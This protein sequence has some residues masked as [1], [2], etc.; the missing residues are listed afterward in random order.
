MSRLLFSSCLLVSIAC[1]PSLKQAQRSTD[2]YE[3]CYGADFDPS[4]TPA[5]RRSC[6]SHWL[7]EQAENQPPELVRYAEMRLGQLALDGSTRPLPSQEPEAISALEHEYPRSPPAEYHTPGC[8]PLCNDR[9]AGCNT[10][11]EMKDKSCV[12]A[13][14][15]E[16][17]VCVDG[18]P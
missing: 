11:C 10:Y 14:E 3:Q 18:C 9:W 12:A 17:R 5:Q 13:C 16:F 6:W 2:Y 7:D 1:G 4:V 15:S 8:V